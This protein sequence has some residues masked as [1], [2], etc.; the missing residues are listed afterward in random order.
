MFPLSQTASCTGIK[1]T[2]LLSSLS[3]HPSHHHPAGALLL[4]CYSMFTTLKCR[5]PASASTL[6]LLS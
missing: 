5:H 3:Q 6:L 4:C 2:W 1:F